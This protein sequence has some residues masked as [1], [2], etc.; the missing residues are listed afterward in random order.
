MRLRLRLLW[1]ILASLWRAPLRARDES[2]LP[3]TVLPTDVDISKISD[4]R[5]FAL[6]DL[7]RMDLAF[8]I[9]LLKVMFKRGWVP[10]ATSA[11]IRFRHPL[12]LFQRYHLKTRAI[13]WDDDT[14]Y[15][16]QVFERKGRVVATGY[17][18]ATLL[19][20]HGRISPKDVLAEIHESPMPPEKPEIVARLEEVNTMIHETQ[21]EKP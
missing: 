11:T 15:F 2:V 18:C 12:R 8:R 7:G 10:L 14:I 4:D 13:Y 6:M 1:L 5:F 3:L 16:Q 21:K 17:V 20:L 19:G 9:G